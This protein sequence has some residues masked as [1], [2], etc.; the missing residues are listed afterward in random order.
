MTSEHLPPQLLEHVAE[1]FRVLG[2]ATRL[3]ILR[4]LMEEGERNVGE[5][6]ERLG[7]T[8]ANVSKHLR[9][10]L[11]EGV[12]A[13]RAAGTAAYY[14]IADPSIAHL[15]DLV[16]NRLREQKAEEARIFAVR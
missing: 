12:V 13:R 3:A 8:Q 11:G 9:I 10:L 5:L 2:D 16:C 7:T 15:C 1:R 6:V 14:S 4:T